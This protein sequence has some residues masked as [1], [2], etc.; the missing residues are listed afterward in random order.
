M[1]KQ[2]APLA[3]ARRHMDAYRE[4]LAASEPHTT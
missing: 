3:V 4:V 1:V 2:F